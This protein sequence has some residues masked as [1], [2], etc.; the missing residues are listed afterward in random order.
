MK[1]PST[2]TEKGTN[3]LAPD[4]E[5]SSSAGSRRRARERED[6]GHGSK[7]H[8][9]QVRYPC[10]VGPDGKGQLLGAQWVAIA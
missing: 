9:S 5:F 3:R 4:I 6:L 10:R 7:L 2:T 8:A 1:P